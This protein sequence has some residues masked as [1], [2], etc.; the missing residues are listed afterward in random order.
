MRMILQ[1]RETC[2]STWRFVV[3]F[4]KAQCCLLLRMA[5]WLI[6][7]F[8]PVFSRGFGLRQ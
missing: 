3:I 1:S 8:D 7:L 6:R 4:C 2:F 5:G